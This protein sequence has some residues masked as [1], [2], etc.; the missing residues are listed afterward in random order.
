MSDCNQVE[1]TDDAFANLINLTTLD[2]SG[3]NQVGITDD[4]FANLINLTTLHIYNTY[5]NIR[6]TNLLIINPYINV[7][8]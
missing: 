1:I 8:Q 6:N 7:R 2:V 5:R 4:A 3:C